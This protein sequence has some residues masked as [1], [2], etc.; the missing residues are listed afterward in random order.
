MVKYCN[1]NKMTKGNCMKRF[2]F[3]SLLIPGLLFIT[4]VG[5]RAIEQDKGGK[6]EKQEDFDPAQ[7]EF[8]TYYFVFLK[9]GENR[10]EMDEKKLQ[11][12]QQAH[13]NHLKWLNDEG[14]TLAALIS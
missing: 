1:I 9:K 8:E 10:Q 4:S 2:I 14:Y 12:I 7:V 3:T 5:I 11:E 13:L 6:D